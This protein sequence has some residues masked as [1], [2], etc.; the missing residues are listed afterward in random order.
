LLNA[1]DGVVPL[2]DVLVFMTT[3][4]LADIDPALLRKGRVDQIF[5]IPLLKDPEIKEYVAVMCPDIQ[6]PETCRFKAIAGCD[7]QALYL[8]NKWDEAAFVASIPTQTQEV[9]N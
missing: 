9:L 2:D 8:D 4:T 7:L 1:L 5:H 3:N 6:I